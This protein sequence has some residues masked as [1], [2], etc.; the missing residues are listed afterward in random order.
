MNVFGDD[1]VKLFANDD[2]DRLV[3]VA[4]CEVDHCW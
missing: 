4:L 1:V 2:V 3:V